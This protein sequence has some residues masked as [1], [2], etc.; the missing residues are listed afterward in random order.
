MDDLKIFKMPQITYNY[1]DIL[2]MVNQYGREKT[3]EKLLENFQD[4]AI[5]IPDLVD[6][7]IRHQIK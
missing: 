2:D 6:E 7:I 5:R 3:I 1:N 4:H